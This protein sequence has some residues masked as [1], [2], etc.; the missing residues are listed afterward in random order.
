MNSIRLG[1]SRVNIDEL[2]HDAFHAI[3]RRAQVRSIRVAMRL[4]A[5]M[6]TLFAEGDLLRV[7][8][9]NLLENALRYSDKGGR[10]NVEA[11]ETE[12]EIVIS[13]C[14][15]GWLIE[16]SDQPHVFDRFFRANGSGGRRPDGLGLGLYLA[17]EIVALHSGRITVSSAPGAGNVFAIH[18]SKSLLAHAVRHDAESAADSRLR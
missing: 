1:R 3:A 6:P 5:A 11:E 8:L 12:H 13:V 17:N 4:P 14:D 18:L 2:M 9:D 7:A 15:D 10:I 16:P